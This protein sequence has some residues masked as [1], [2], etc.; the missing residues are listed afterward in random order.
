MVQC[1]GESAVDAYRTPRPEYG[2]R[3]R[4]PWGLG[5]HAVYTP[6]LLLFGDFNV[7]TRVVK[8]DGQIR[9]AEWQAMAEGPA[10]KQSPN[11]WD[12]ISLQERI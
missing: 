9:R 6:R 8:N 7:A 1:G 4:T 12:S 11:F 2:T 5:V 3:D 10:G